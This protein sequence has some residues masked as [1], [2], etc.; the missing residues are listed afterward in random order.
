M[1]RTP[2]VAN[3]F[4]KV[5]E[6]APAGANTSSNVQKMKGTINE[7]LTVMTESHVGQ[8]V[9]TS[10]MIVATGNSLADLDIGK[11]AKAA[12]MSQCS[13]ASLV[14]DEQNVLKSIYD[15]IE[16]IQM[17]NSALR[18]AAEWVT[19]KTIISEHRDNWGEN[20]DSVT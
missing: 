10:G 13:G 12:T 9:V 5:R 11:C 8:T 19:K 1:R 7:I 2:A 4:V 18:F 17:K 16:N 3:V 20:Y 14:S 15:H 6:A